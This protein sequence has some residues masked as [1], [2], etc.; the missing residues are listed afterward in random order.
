MCPVGAGVGFCGVLM[1]LSVALLCGY[2]L[3]R[4]VSGWHVLL[5]SIMDAY[6]YQERLRQPRAHRLMLRS[7]CRLCS[8]SPSAPRQTLRRLRRPALFPPCLG[9]RAH[10]SVPARVAGA[11]GEPQAAALRP[12]DEAR[13][14]PLQRRVLAVR[15][16]VSPSDV[17]GRRARPSAHVGRICGMHLGFSDPTSQTITTS[18]IEDVTEED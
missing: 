4:C 11:V 10:P 15:R 2:S 9:G 14:V 18:M 16:R 7:W 6:R 1:V 5:V 3:V 12:P 8:A 17:R 13:E